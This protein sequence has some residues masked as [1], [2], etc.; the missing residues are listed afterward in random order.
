MPARS[1]RLLLMRIEAII[2]W[3]RRGIEVQ[4]EF[5]SV[6]SEVSGRRDLY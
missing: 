2:E 6:L 1:R 4:G 3:L 5:D